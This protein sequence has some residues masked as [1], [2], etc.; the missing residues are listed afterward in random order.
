MENENVP[1]L[2][3]QWCEILKDIL[4]NNGVNN[5]DDIAIGEIPMYFKEYIFRTLQDG[6]KHKVYFSKQLQNNLKYNNFK[7]VIEDI[8]NK[9][10]DGQGL[11]QYLSKGIVKNLKEP[12]RLLNDWGIIH[13]HLSNDIQADGFCKRTNELL[14]VYRNFLNSTDMYFLDIF[15][16]GRWNEKEIVEIIHKNWPESIRYFKIDCLEICHNPTNNEIKDLRKSNINSAIELSD[17]TAYM[18][19]GGG[20]TMT[21]TNMWSMMDQI[22]SLKFF[23]KIEKEIAEESGISAENLSL[24]LENGKLVIKS[25]NRNI[26]DIQ[27]PY[28]SILEQF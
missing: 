7:T 17:G 12:D 2:Y 27:S 16:H 10:Q 19:I 18:A 21:G 20:M 6:L 28:D 11:T 13:M 1:A 3:S 4:K 5:L 14:F 24:T 22:N 8:K 23:R 25:N 9:A 26:C 15:E